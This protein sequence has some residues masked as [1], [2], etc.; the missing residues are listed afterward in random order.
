MTAPGFAGLGPI[1]KERF[2]TG[3]PRNRRRLNVVFITIVPSPYQRDLVSAL[4]DRGDI[5]LSV[6]YMEA[7]SP[8]SPW[9]K[10]PLRS[11]ERIVPGFWVPFRG[12][13]WH[14]NW[15]LPSFAA[16]DFVILSSFSS[17]TG[18]WLMRR[19]LRGKRW[20]FWG[21]RLR[22]QTAGWRDTVQS[23]LITPLDRAT[24][25]VGIG[26]AAEE[27]YRRRFPDVRHFCIPYHC[28]RSAFME[29]GRQIEPDAPLTFFFCGQMIRRK[30]VDLLLA[31][32]DR[33][34]AK[35]L[36]VRLLLIGREADLP[37]FLA[38][39]S[40]AARSRISYEGFQ[41]PERLPS[42]FSRADVF[43]LPSRYDGWGVVVNQALGAGLPVISSQ[44]VGAGLDLVEENVNGLRFTS[45]DV[46]GLR[47]A[48]QILAANPELARAW[49]EASR[50][51]AVEITPE[52]GAEKWAQVFGALADQP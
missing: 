24:A 2:I 23:R 9:P 17:W 15:R 36:D 20:L 16:A 7:E 1:A 47:N 5:N 38:G 27:D 42:Y 34:V 6:C 29:S 11:F 37:E 10:M 40:P 43:V 26:R 35:G 39:V 30:G 4:N 21:E 22:A 41:P 52:A 32:F 3:A 50:R 45:G 12:A 25:I 19:G 31:A 14:F 48:M 8:D 44:A 13:R 49:G 46:E 18:Q 51:K 33:L 28:D